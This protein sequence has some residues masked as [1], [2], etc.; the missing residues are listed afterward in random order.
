MY[1]TVDFVGMLTGFIKYAVM[2]TSSPTNMYK[3]VFQ[4]DGKPENRAIAIVMTPSIIIIWRF[5]MVL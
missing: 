1:G 5:D 3:T 4:D 2:M